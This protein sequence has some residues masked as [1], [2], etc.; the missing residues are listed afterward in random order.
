MTASLSLFPA[1]VTRLANFPLDWKRRLLA[2]DLA[3]LRAGEA[4]LQDAIANISPPS[5]IS[6]LSH[7]CNTY[8]H[9]VSLSISLLGGMAGAW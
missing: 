1:P 7:G 2:Y 4:M 8:G 9:K 5:A 3:T 6:F